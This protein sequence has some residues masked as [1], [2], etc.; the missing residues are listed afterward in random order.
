MPP[1]KLLPCLCGDEMKVVSGPMDAYHVI[2]H[3]GPPCGRLAPRIQTTAAAA[4]RAW[5]WGLR[6][7]R[8]DLQ[9]SC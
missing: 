4:V 5:N 8:P 3:R 1:E 7:M 9:P 6:V 2:F